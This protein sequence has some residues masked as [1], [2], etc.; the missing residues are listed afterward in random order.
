MRE[1]R[2]INKLSP[3]DY[4]TALEG[5]PDIDTPELLELP[6]NCRAAWENNAAHNIL[7]GLRG[8]TLVT[9]NIPLLGECLFDYKRR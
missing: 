2:R 8:S 6:A 1:P 3:Q 9:S 4:I 5:L 7:T